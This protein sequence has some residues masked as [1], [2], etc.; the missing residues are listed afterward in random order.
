MKVQPPSKYELKQKQTVKDFQPIWTLPLL[1][2]QVGTVRKLT[3][4]TNATMHLFW[5]A[6]WKDFW[7]LTLEKNRSTLFLFTQTIWE[8][9]WKLTLEKSYTNAT[10]HLFWQSISSWALTF[11]KST[12]L[13]AM[14][15][16]KLT[17]LSPSSP[18][19]L[20]YG[21]Q[22]WESGDIIILNQSSGHHQ[23]S[24]IPGWWFLS[25]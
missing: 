4:A 20:N 14:W 7:K 15:S 10:M 21:Y 2:I 11:A 19:Q 3:N 22:N 17:R 16:L 6:V 24:R 18:Q 13:K 25:T 23:N 5:Q 12:L 1:N 8:H 9:I